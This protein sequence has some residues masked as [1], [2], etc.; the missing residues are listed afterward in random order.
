MA[1][2]TDREPAPAWSTA[3]ATIGIAVVVLS[4]TTAGRR[5]R[6]GRGVTIGGDDDNDIVLDDRTVSRRHCEL[7]RTAQGVRVVDLRSKNGTWV[8]GLRVD[9]ATVGVGTVLKVGGVEI[10]LLPKPERVEVPP[11]D[12]HEFGRALGKSLAMRRIFGVL[13]YVAPSEATVL[14]T[15]ETGTGKDILARAI[16]EKSARAAGPFVV[17]DCGAVARGVVES[18]LFG[19][20]R[21]AFTGAA[22]TR[23]GAFELAAKGTLFLDEIGELPLDVQPKLLRVLEARELR[24]VGG[25]KTIRTDTRIIAA[26]RRDLEAEV[27]AGRFRE[28]LYFRLAVVPIEIPP[29]RDRR[30]DIPLLVEHLLAGLG[31]PG[32]SLSVGVTAMAELVAAPWPGNVRE[33]RNVLERAATLARAGVLSELHIAPLSERLA[34]CETYADAQAT[35]ERGWLANLVASHGGDLA[36]AAR[37]AGLEEE[38]LDQMLTATGIAATSVRGA[39]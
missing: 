10:A 3:A 15:G 22:A 33:L 9:Q 5:V 6:L 20:E 7:I 28:D 38:Q 16:A 18:E 13:E 11:S 12:R 1:E 36:S 27:A 2:D 17:V 19:H 23:R 14:L 39:G 29:L 21:G 34:G 35:F 26:T 32:A 4:G 30:E 24:K 37:A 25:S 31:S 8:G